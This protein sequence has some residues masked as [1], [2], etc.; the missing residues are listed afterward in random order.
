MS[1]VTVVGPVGSLIQAAAES[2]PS[3]RRTIRAHEVLERVTG[4]MR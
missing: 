2:A 3:F 4:T 1:Q